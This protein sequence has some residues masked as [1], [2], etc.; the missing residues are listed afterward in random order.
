M[1]TLL[2][3]F[4]VTLSQ[5]RWACVLDPTLA[6]S[7]HGLFLA[8]QLGK[9]MELWVV[10]ELWHI[11]D[12][13]H[14]FL[15]HPESMA[16][17]SAK[18]ENLP[19]LQQPALDEASLRNWEQ[20]RAD[21]DLIGLN[22]FWIGDALGQSLL[23]DGMKPEIIKRY[24]QLACSFDAHLSQGADISQPLS[25]AFRDAAALSAT[26][27]SAFILTHQSSTEFA[28]HLPPAICRALDSCGVSCQA[29]SPA[30]EIAAIERDYLQHLLVHAGL[31][32]LMWSGLHLAVLHLT[33]PTTTSSSGVMSDG[34]PDMQFPEMADLEESWEFE[35]G[36]RPDSFPYLWEGVQGFW[37][38]I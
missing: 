35:G 30:D 24:E 2:P 32:K 15:R 28:E 21:I 16:L 37:Y 14:F 9:V 4:S 11:L 27:G 20:S 13:T 8:T 6:L 31:S 1:A 19:A 38:P 18:S 17:P 7:P 29:V 25:A 23:P 3:T 10:R 5:Q 33:V 26:L 34:F 36:R 22:V 12:N